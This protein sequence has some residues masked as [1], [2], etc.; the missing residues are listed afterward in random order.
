MRT[1][2]AIVAT[3]FLPDLAT[4]QKIVSFPTEDGGVVF[5]DVYGS[6]DRAMDAPLKLDVLAAVRY[7]RARGAK[8]VSAVGSS[9]GGAAA[10]DASVASRPGEIDR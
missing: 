2:I 6:G 1:L 8:N 7:L 4:A 3:L 9:M 10:G 5:A